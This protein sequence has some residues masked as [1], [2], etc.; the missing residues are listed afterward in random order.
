M[1]GREVEPH[2]IGEFADAP[3]DLQE[4][5]SERV[6]LVGGRFGPGEPPP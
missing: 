3:A 6:E 5:E 4:L 1:A 2:P